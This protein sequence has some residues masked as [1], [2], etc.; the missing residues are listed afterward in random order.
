MTT[1]ESGATTEGT[2]GVKTGV[3]SANQS[4]ELVIKIEGV[5]NDKGQVLVAIYNSAEGFPG[6]PE[7]AVVKEA[8]PAKNGTVELSVPN[9]K[10]GSYAVALHHD[11]SGD[12]K[13]AYNFV[14]IPK[15]GFGFSGNKRILFGPPSF[16]NAKFEVKDGRTSCDI[17]MKYF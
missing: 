3:K 16:N 17:K 4:A 13:M 12:Q 5:R 2:T 7:G 8:V 10:P 14:G 6:K 15:E 1:L 11:E 9:L